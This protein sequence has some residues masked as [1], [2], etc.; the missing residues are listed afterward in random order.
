LCRTATM[1]QKKKFL[2][3]DPFC[4]DFSKNFLSLNCDQILSVV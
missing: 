2:K 1:P 4:T 3:P